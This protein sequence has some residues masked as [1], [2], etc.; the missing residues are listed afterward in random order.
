MR[1]KMRLFVCE[2]CLLVLLLS[3]FFGFVNVRV[4]SGQEDQ[5]VPAPQIY[6]TTN[7]TVGEGYSLGVSQGSAVN[8]NWC[9]RNLTQPF[10]NVTDWQGNTFSNLTGSQYMYDVDLSS[11]YPVNGSGTPSSDVYIDCSG[12]IIPIYLYNCSYFDMT[13]SNIT[14]LDNVPTFTN[15]MTFHNI[16]MDTYGHG[17]SSITLTFIQTFIANLTE[18][19]IRTDTFADLSNLTLYTNSTNEAHAN[20]TF[21]FNLDYVVALF[22]QTQ[23]NLQ[24]NIT[25]VPGEP[26]CSLSPSNVTSTEVF[27]SIPSVGNLQFSLANMTL[28]DSYVESQGNTM[29]ANKTA[30]SS[31]DANGDR[32]LQTFDNLTYGLTTSIESDP[33]ITIVHDSLATVT[34]T[35]TAT[36]TQTSSSSTSST[37]SSSSS[38]SPSPSLSPTPSASQQPTPSPE[39]S[40]TSISSTEI[41]LVTVTVVIAVSVAALAISKRHKR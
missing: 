7:L 41:V 37:S 2:F 3:S 6:T 19:T 8:A 21:S 9:V 28:T 20:S 27:Y 17:N 22:N 33:T 1:L 15:N 4:G 24:G 25:N 31:L 35:P 32:L 36:P 10:D 11:M 12:T 18:F 14:Y 23:V 16:Q 38:P 5:L 30:T 40:A 26:A 34:S 29:F 13:T 39:P